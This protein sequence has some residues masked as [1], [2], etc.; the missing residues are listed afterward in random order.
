[1]RKHQ[2]KKSLI[3]SDLLKASLPTAIAS[4]TSSLRTVMYVKHS[5]ASWIIVDTILDSQIP[6]MRLAS[7]IVLVCE[8]HIPANIRSMSAALTTRTQVIAI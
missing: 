8:V 6:R 4:P 2:N 3:L 5:M 7:K 1:M